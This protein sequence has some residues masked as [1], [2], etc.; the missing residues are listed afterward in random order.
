MGYSHYYLNNN[1]ST[2]EQ[3]NKTLEEVKKICELFVHM[4]IKDM[5]DINEI[6]VYQGDELI[7]FLYL[8]MKYSY[9]V[10]T[11]RA[12]Y[13][14]CVCMLFLA[15]A[16]NLDGFTFSTNGSIKEWRDPID[17]YERHITKLKLIEKDHEINGYDYVGR[18]IIDI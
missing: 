6:K 15:C 14:P 8:T 18:I 16:N 12:D 4:N 9:Y 1:T 13:D 5:S 3:K 11:N 7:F 17:K 10:K 2:I